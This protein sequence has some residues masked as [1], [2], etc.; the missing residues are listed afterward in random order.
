MSGGTAAMSETEIEQ[1]LVNEIKKSLGDTETAAPEKPEP[2]VVLEAKVKKA[3]KGQKMFSDVF[4]YKPVSRPDFPVSLFKDDDF[5]E[6][7]R[8]FIPA[9][10]DPELDG[11]KPQKEAVEQLVSGLEEGDRISISG[12]TGSGKSSMVKYVCQKLRRPFIRINMNGD[13]ESSA[14]FGQLVV[15]D[16]G[17]VW[18]NGPAPEGLMYGAVICIDEWTVMPPEITMNFQNPLEHGGFLFLKEKPGTAAEKVINPHEQT[19]YVFCDNTQGQ[20]DD[21]GAFAGTNVQN[22]ATLDRFDMAIHLDYLGVDHETSV[23]LSKVKGLDKGIV[24]KMIQY[25][26]QIRNAYAKTEMGLT[27]SPRTLINWG[28]KIEQYGSCKVSLT[29]CF[30]NKLRD[31]DKKV[32]TELYTKVFGKIK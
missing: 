22:T 16:G 26:G 6:A 31:S 17:T 7:V 4:G 14:L 11:Y 25:A 30:L 9:V 29:Y 5:N 2:E 23:I 21:T 10:D 3:A 1:F 8:V 32:A 27:M 13:I 28:R 12:P 18:K 15:E 24:K 19:R 20:G